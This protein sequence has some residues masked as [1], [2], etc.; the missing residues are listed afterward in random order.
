MPAEIPQATY[1]LQL[2]AS[3]GFEDAAKLVPYLKSL[4]ITHLY[5][6]PFLRARKGSTHGYDIGDHTQLNPE[7]GGKAGFET[8]SDALAGA[9]MGLILDFVPNHMGVGYSD[10]AWWLDILEWGPKSPYAKS[11]DIDWDMLPHR[12]KPG[13]LL[14]LLGMSYGEA[15]NRGQIELR[16]EA[17]TGEFSAWYFEHR[18]PVAPPRY[19]ELLRAIVTA[20]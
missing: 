18:L 19:S 11:F 2:N 14:P 12:R 16:Y 17:E 4:G 7:F 15:L 13:L 6:S 5:A 3:F 20:A 1:R 10:N 9:D 8:L